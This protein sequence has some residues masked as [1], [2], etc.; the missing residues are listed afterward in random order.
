MKEEAKKLTN[1]YTNS[2]QEM[3]DDYVKYINSVKEV[4]E[5]TPIKVNKKRGAGNSL[6]VEIPDAKYKLCD[7]YEETVAWTK[8]I[9]EVSEVIVN[10]PLQTVGILCR[11]LGETAEYALEITEK[12]ATFAANWVAEKLSNLTVNSKWVKKIIKKLKM[13]LLFV[14]KSILQG[15]LYML[16]I[17]KR[18]LTHCS[19]GKVTNS[20]SSGKALQGL[21]ATIQV[22]GKIIEVIIKVIESLLSSLVGF[23]LDGGCMGFFITPKSVTTGLM[24]PS[25]GTMKPM[26]T[27]QDIYSNIADALITPIEEGFRQAAIIATTGKSA[28]MGAEIA[29]NTAAIVGTD[30]I[31]DIPDSNVKLEKSFDLSLLKAAIVL[32]LSLLFTPEALPKYERLHPGNLGFM[33][34]LLTSFEPTMKKCFGLP[35]FP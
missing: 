27:N 31:I 19:N 3:W 15:K 20:N 22:I 34:W 6:R 9:A 25:N 17:T 14:K 29:T 16:K 8:W 28:A 13:C 5:N 12:G 2:M 4:C 23:T 10:V 24:P 30:D 33:A 11:A 32:L 26:N 7:M 35:G 1:G 18:I 21:L